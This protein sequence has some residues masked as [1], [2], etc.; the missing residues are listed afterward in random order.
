MALRAGAAGPLDAAAVDLVR[1][2]TVNATEAATSTEIRPALA[3]TIHTPCR[4]F[5]RAGV[6][7]ET[8]EEPGGAFCAWGCGFCGTACHRCPSHHHSPS[9]EYCVISSPPAHAPCDPAS[10]PESTPGYIPPRW[11][12]RPG[13]DGRKL[14]EPR[15]SGR[16]D[17]GERLDGGYRRRVVG[18]EERTG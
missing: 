1:P 2:A 18:P 10:Q 16:E 14:S 15:F 17:A 8:V 6:C 11:D 9:F 13:G 5:R 12:K 3:A 7:S 4:R